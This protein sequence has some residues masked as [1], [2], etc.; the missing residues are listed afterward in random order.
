[1]QI[2]LSDHFTYRK[3][4]RFTLSSVVMMVFTSVY[5]VVDGLFVSNLVGDL[6]LSAVNIM[7]PLAMI[8]G[9]FGF[10]LGTGGSA[11]V[12]RTLGEGQPALASRYFSMIVYAVILL[13]AVLTA[14]CLLFLE[15]LA[16]LA[17][18]SD[19]LL[20]DC[21]V[22]GGILLGGSV[23]FMLQT[24][25]QSFFVVAEKPHL[26]LF[27]SIAA[28]ATNMV[29]DYILIA[30]CGL[31]V[32]GA[33]IATVLGYLVGGVLPLLYFLRPG[34][35]GLRLTRTRLY[36]R[37]LLQACVNGSS[38]L[39][40]NI[41]SSF[42]SILYNIQL[43]RLIGELGVA[44][45]SVMMYVDFVFI[46]AFLGFS[47][48]CAP[49]I[50]YH[51]GADN[52][53]ELKNVFRKSMAVIG[54]TSCAMVLLSEVLS[55]PLS[56]AFVGY[57]P[58]LLELTVHGFRLFALCYLFSGINIYASAF[59][60]ALCNGG[61]SALISFLRTLLLRGGMVLLMPLLF[62]LDGIWTAVIAAEGIGAVISLALLWYKRKTYHY[63]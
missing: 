44:A 15:P 16:R 40:S 17:G 61:L 1:M 34:R 11:I 28:G 37:E 13:G 46:A 48:G 50:S 36:G 51:Y 6:A 12:A 53:A 14:G 45:Y 20:H 23:P 63:G 60:T 7:F 9:A 19:L 26:G 27:L 42:V 58:E 54:V 4:L 5:S 8:V 22:Y 2:K 29:F 24:T 39:M 47:L 49:V 56:A 62:G 33:A 21:L 41:S 18:A 10:M 31:G 55:R 30:V 43:M 35:D 32:A 52:H 38:E 3:L 57:H 59:F 25:L